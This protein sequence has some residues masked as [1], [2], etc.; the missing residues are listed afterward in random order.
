MDPEVVSVSP[1]QFIAV[2]KA[3]D[4]SKINAWVKELIEK[5]PALSQ[6]TD[7]GGFH[8][9]GVVIRDIRFVMDDEADYEQLKALRIA[10]QSFM[11]DE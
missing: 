11:Q 8:N 10:V 7:V 1:N 3:S 2:I 6:V 4:N 5:Y 9:A